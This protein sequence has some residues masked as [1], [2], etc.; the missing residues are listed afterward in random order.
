MIDKNITDAAKQGDAD[1]QFHLATLYAGG[2][3]I[4]A[5]PRLSFRWLLMAA[6]HGHSGAAN[7]MKAYGLFY[8]DF[9]DMEID[10][11][12]YAFEEED[13]VH[14]LYSLGL[15]SLACEGFDD[16]NGSFLSESEITAMRYL[17]QAAKAGHG[18]AKAFIHD[19]FV[20]NMGDQSF[21]SINK[22]KAK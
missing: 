18:P 15:R 12:M 14:S 7:I 16:E 10:D 5:D 2:K 9:L 20:I 11:L 17:A 19:Y 4:D 8:F 13:D 1:A 21:F 22:N 6:K 3:G